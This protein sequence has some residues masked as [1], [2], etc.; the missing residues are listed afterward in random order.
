[1][2]Y[3]QTRWASQKQQLVVDR[4]MQGKGMGNLLEGWSLVWGWS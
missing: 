4:A 1:M 3:L 2:N